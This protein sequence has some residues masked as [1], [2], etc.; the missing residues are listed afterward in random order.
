MESNV[1][2]W[3][4]KLRSTT[5]G[6]V[7]LYHCLRFY[8]P[9][10]E[11]FSITATLSPQSIS[12][13]NG[14]LRVTNIITELVRCE[15]FV[16]WERLLLPY[17]N[18]GIWMGTKGLSGFRDCNHGFPNGIDKR[19][20][21]S[22]VKFRNQLV[23]GTHFGVFTNGLV[24]SNWVQFQMPK[25]EERISDLTVKGDSLLILTRNYLYCTTDLIHLQNS[26][27][28]QIQ[29]IKASY[30]VSYL[31]GIAQWRAFRICWNAF[32]DLLELY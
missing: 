16:N 31:M 28:R 29:D 32:V 7:L 26:L 9:F 12:H 23:A 5:N 3:V 18:I 1:A 14:C 20:I 25:G 15:V 30:P 27:F 13:A 22:I 24:P 8:L 4:R 17:G 21:Y 10:Q 19:K 6:P 2:K 11:S